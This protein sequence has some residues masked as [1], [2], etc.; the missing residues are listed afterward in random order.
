MIFNKSNTLIKES[1]IKSAYF[2]ISQLNS[3]PCLK[4]QLLDS[5]VC[6]DVDAHLGLILLFG[7][8]VG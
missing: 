7:S 1:L 5:R 6:S 8:S 2:S 4:V 3:S